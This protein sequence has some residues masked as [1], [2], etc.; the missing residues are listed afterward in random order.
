MK[1][2]SNSHMSNTTMFAHIHTMDTVLH[3]R[4]DMLHKKFSHK[5]YK[6]G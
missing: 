6:K 3:L 2:W 4:H 5:C 1:Q